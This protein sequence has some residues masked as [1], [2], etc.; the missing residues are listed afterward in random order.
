MPTN[1]GSEMKS[2][3]LWRRVVC[4]VVLCATFISATVIAPARAAEKHPFGVDDYSQLHSARPLDVSPDGTTVLYQVSHD[5][6]KGST[7]HEW[8]LIGHNG[9]NDRKLDLPENF[10]P[11]G[12]MPSGFTKDEPALYG[13]LK[14][15][16]NNQ[17]AIVPLAKGALVQILALPRGINDAIISPDGTR[18]AVLA[19]PQPND[20]LDD[21]RTV[22][23]SDQTSL[24][25]VG[26][27]GEN[28][29]WW[30]PALKDI[31]G[32]AWSSDGGKIGV[33]SQT[34]HIGHHD[35]RSFVDVC[36]AGGAQRIAAIPNSAGGIAWTDAGRELAFAS[37][38]TSVLTPDHV[39]TVPAAGGSPLDRTPE[40]NGTAA[41][42]KNDPHG[43][44][45]VEMHRGV[46]VELDSY[47]DGKLKVAFRWPE[48]NVTDPAFSPLSSSPQAL[49]FA[50]SDPMHSINVAVNDG[51][52]INRITH[53]GDDTLANVNLG[54]ARVVN[55]TSK[56]GTK[57]EGIVTFPADYKAGEKYKFLNLPHGGPEANDYLSF[58]VFARLISGLG[59]VVM[60]PQYRGSTGYGSEF[61]N[62]LYQQFGSVAYRD[63]DSATDYVIAQG[64][65]DPDRLAMFGWSGGGFMTAWTVTQTNRYRA[66]IEGAGITDWLS[67]IPTS[68]IQQTDY[69]AR[70]QEKDPA[71]FLKYSPVMYADR[72]TTPLLILQGQADQRVPVMQGREF[73][74]LLAERGK[75]VRMVT[76]PKSPHFPRLAEQRRNVFQEIAAWLSK[77]NP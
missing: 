71:P 17:L 38:T 1:E 64:W 74:I 66:A 15:D 12:F 77:Y 47:R 35:V 3:N 59:Y 55:W 40:L 69:D 61:L 39:W 27:H 46:Q 60:Q 14:A 16:D 30:C 58:D 36:T 43:T 75:T 67:F 73:F 68:D 24:Y 53:E 10:M 6:D 23:E 51:A 48:G 5:G 4:G 11:I 28:G 22:V 49:A 54:E 31:T 56:D 76:Y 20:P 57:L 42:V 72:V 8:H 9:K 33:L 21:V 7:K 29:A 32:I 62:A 65:A 50:V 2:Q 70:F 34:Q 13:S 45:W 63:V 25:V 52:T 18:F 44:V 19:S 26:V 37:T 41:T